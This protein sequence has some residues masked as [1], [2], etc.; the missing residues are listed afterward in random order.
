MSWIA[1]LNK[2]YNN[3]C[4]SNPED[5]LPIAHTTQKADIEVVI[6]IY[7]NFVSSRVVEEGRETLIPC[8]EGSASRSGKNPVC[9]PLHDKLQYVAGDYT[10]YG[11]AKGDSFHEGYMAGLK[12][13]CE[14]P[15]ANKKVCAVYEYLKKSCLVHDLVRDGSLYAPNSKL[16]DKW[17][18][19]KTEVPPIFKVIVGNQS[20]A[21][22]RFCVDGLDSPSNLWEDSKVQQDYI[23]YYLSKQRDR[24]FCY[25]TGEA[26]PCS[27]NHP[28]KIRHTGDKAKLISA[29]DSTGFT[30]R[31]RF[32]N[33]EEAVQISYEVSQKAHNALKWLIANQGKRFG[34][35][36]EKVFLLWGTE[37]QKLPCLTGDTADE[38]LQED[39]D[40]DVGQWADTKEEIAKRFNRAISG[41]KAILSSYTELALMGLDSATTGRLS[42]TFYREFHGQQGNELFDNIRAW[43]E[44][45][46]WL[47]KYKR[48]KNKQIT[49]EGSPGLED[50]A[51]IAFGTEQ[52]GM[53]KAK[54]KVVGATVE[55]LIPCIV[56]KALIPIDI[57]NALVRK[58]MHPQSYDE[59]YNWS[60]VISV[61]CSIYKRHRLEKYKEVWDVNVNLDSDDII[62]NCGRL[63]AVADEIERYALALQNEKRQTNAV[64]LFTRFA[65]DPCNTWNLISI[66]LNPYIQR[67]G[68][69]GNKLNKLKEDI[70]SKISPTAFAELKNLDGRMILGFDAQKNFIRNN[71]IKKDAGGEENESIEEQD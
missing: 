10:N 65:S 52:N 58:A 62:Y 44:E 45:C 30:Y 56:E 17:D 47:H 9:H 40:E 35:K 63:L 71:I 5:L 15:F 37:G 29:N 53:I 32:Q 39:E 50:I 24:Q 14:S 34:D 67:L 3:I 13:W 49:F 21:F 54:N 28:S 64:K 46:S 70:S 38:A 26:V 19:P 6:D 33:A 51:T 1:M 4:L 43:H 55:R 41:Y 31:G 23:K 22:I 18:G 12:D 66:K 36:G 59:D 69:R 57:V 8:S 42:I 20:D 60:K 11:G 27:T 68:K 61:T 7:G 16:I 48:H 2:T 25:V